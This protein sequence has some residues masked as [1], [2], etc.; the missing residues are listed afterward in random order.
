M[1]KLLIVDDEPMIVRAMA[2]LM[3]SQY[4]VLTATSVVVALALLP[5]VD[6]VL[7][8]WNMPDGGGA[9]ILRASK[10][11]VVLMTANPD[12]AA[13]TPEGQTAAAI[14]AKPAHVDEISDAIATALLAVESFAS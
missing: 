7:S 4:E 11:P 13:A 3:T 5:S 2:R 12:Q 1:K 10:Q 8:D 9:A 14:I 6:V